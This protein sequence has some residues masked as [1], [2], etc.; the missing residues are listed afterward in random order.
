MQLQ[1]IPDLPRCPKRILLAQPPNQLL[2][3]IRDRRAA[4]LAARPPAPPHKAGLK[5][6]RGAFLSSMR[7]AQ[8]ASW[9]SAAKSLAASTALGVI[10]DR[11]KL[12]AYPM[13]SAPKPAARQ[14]LVSTLRMAFMPRECQNV[15]MLAGWRKSWPRRRGRDYSEGSF[16]SYGTSF[17]REMSRSPIRASAAMRMCSCHTVPFAS[18]PTLR[19]RTASTMPPIPFIDGCGKPA[20]RHDASTM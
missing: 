2:H 14:V 17:C 3:F 6:G 13:I 16:G 9:L 1:R 8:T 5:R 4:W 10:S 18:T 15:P 19:P 20:M 7:C 12:T 11:P